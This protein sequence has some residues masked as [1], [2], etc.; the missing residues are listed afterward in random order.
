MLIHFTTVCHIIGESLSGSPSVSPPSSSAAGGGGG[1]RD[2]R[3]VVM[4]RRSGGSGR[5]RAGWRRRREA[6][7]PSQASLSPSAAFACRREGQLF[8]TCCFTNTAESVETISLAKVNFSW[9]GRRT[10]VL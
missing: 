3:S 5:T 2:E 10:V 8:E 4:L 9:Q 1:G 7:N 6:L